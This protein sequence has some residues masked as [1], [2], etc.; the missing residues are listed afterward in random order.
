MGFNPSKLGDEYYTVSA[1]EEELAR[2]TMQQL[3]FQMSKDKGELHILEPTSEAK[4]QVAE[5]I[6]QLGEMGYLSEADRE[7]I[8]LGLDLKSDSKQPIIVSDDYSVQNLAEHLQLKYR[9][10]ANYGIVYKYEWLMYCPA[11][12]RKYRP[13]MKNCT[14]C[15]TGLKRKVLSK[16]K[17]TS[18]HA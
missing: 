18:K 6:T 13:P 17:T 16:K 15:G 7:V 9:G 5:A 2:G 3:R 8:A 14:F 11:C 1:V 10:L 4:K 12:Y